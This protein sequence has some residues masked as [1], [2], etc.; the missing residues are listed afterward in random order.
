MFSARALWAEGGIHRFYL[1]YAVVEHSLMGDQGC[2][3]ELMELAKK[4]RNASDFIANFWYKKALSIQSEQ[5]D[6]IMKRYCAL[7]E[8]A[9]TKKEEDDLETKMFKEIDELCYI[10]YYDN[11]DNINKM[12]LDRLRVEKAKQ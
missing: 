2:F 4:N 8:K 6:K 7:L 9:K 11:W 10:V 12:I 5:L 3:D 1:Q